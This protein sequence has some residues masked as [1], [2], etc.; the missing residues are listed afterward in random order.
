MQA[1]L[2][3]LLQIAPIYSILKA[4]PSVLVWSDSWFCQ[5]AWSFLHA[6]SILHWIYCSEEDRLSSSSEARSSWN[7]SISDSWVQFTRVPDMVDEP[8]NSFGSITLSCNAGSIALSPDFSWIARRYK[9]WLEDSWY[10]IF[11]WPLRSTI[12]L[13]PLALFDDVIVLDCSVNLS[14]DCLIMS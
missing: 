13:H 1:F 7:E 14:M 3:N 6:T 5:V 11:K 8:V 4:S 10:P 2:L 12:E 9:N